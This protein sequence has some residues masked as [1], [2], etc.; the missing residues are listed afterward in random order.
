MRN[1][2]SSLLRSENQAL[3]CRSIRLHNGNLSHRTT[4]QRLIV[5]LNTSEW[6]HQNDSFIG[7]NRSK[8]PELPSLAELNVTP[9][10]QSRHA[11]RTLRTESQEG[12]LF[13]WPR[14]QCQRCMPYTARNAKEIAFVDFVQSGSL[15]DLI[16]Q[17]GD[18]NIKEL[19]AFID[20]YFEMM[21]QETMKEVKEEECSNT[22]PINCEMSGITEVGLKYLA[23]IDRKLSKLNILE[24][25]QKDLKELNQNLKHFN[26]IFQ[27]L[28]DR[29]KEAG[30]SSQTSETK[31]SAETENHNDESCSVSKI[32]Q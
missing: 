29:G 6:L 12:R 30:L 3:G 27:E 19:E 13:E 25:V 11:L 5:L 17:W 22:S 26:Q 15:Q 4:G 24:D 23:S 8:R 18:S 10:D 21:W 7:V 9:D 1:T 2:D 14:L 16:D 20:S 28:R 31:E 32:D